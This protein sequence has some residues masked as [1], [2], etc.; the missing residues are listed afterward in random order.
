MY[1]CNWKH[2]YIHTKYTYIH[3]IRRTSLDLLATAGLDSERRSPCKRGEASR[4]RLLNRE[5]RWFQA[6]WSR[7]NW[8]C[9]LQVALSLRLLPLPSTT[10]L[11]PI[12]IIVD[13]WDCW[14]MTRGV[15]CV[16]ESWYDIANIINIPKLFQPVVSHPRWNNP[17]HS[18][19]TWDEATG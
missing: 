8:C 10:F 13:Q 9:H 16:A 6:H 19:D 4:C 11:P 3:T 1:V 18:H 14:Y 15:S 2:A 5:G 17:I 7:H 12:I